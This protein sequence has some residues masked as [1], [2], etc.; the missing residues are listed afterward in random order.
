MKIKINKKRII[1]S[2]VVC[3]CIFLVLLCLGKRF[4]LAPIVHTIVVFFEVLFSMLTLLFMAIA[5]PDIFSWF[6]ENI[7]SSVKRFMFFIVIFLL[8][9]GGISFARTMDE[10]VILPQL[11]SPPDEELIIFPPILLL[12]DEDDVLGDTFVFPEGADEK[13]F[14]ALENLKEDKNT[15]VQEIHNIAIPLLN[16][17]LKTHYEKFQNAPIS[18]EKINISLEL[19]DEITDFAQKNESILKKSD[20]ANYRFLAATLSLFALISADD[21]DT[22]PLALKAWNRVWASFENVAD[23]SGI[24]E[25][26]RSIFYALAA[27]GAHIRIGKSYDDERIAGKRASDIMSCRVLCVRLMDIARGQKKEVARAF[28]FRGKELTDLAK[29]EG[30]SLPGDGKMREDEARRIDAFFE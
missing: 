10:G 28:A 22:S 15:L 13:L 1:V 23:I 4:Q 6:K 18:R 24:P 5:I 30:L 12:L 8:V 25:V 3:I 16:G 21:L 29:E 20:Y 19:T 7:V 9:A 14:S 11:P 17:S 2:L 27:S 26:E